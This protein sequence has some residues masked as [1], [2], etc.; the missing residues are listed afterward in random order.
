MDLKLLLF[1]PC[2]LIFAEANA[3][4]Q[5]TQRT[6][7][8]NIGR[9]R[10]V[11][12]SI[13]NRAYLGLGHYN[14]TGVE[15]YFSDWW[16]FDPATGAWTQ[17][18]DYPGNSG[19]GE[20][21]AHGMGL[22]S[23][24]FVGLGELDDYSLYK[25]DPQTNSWTQVASPTSI[26]GTF[27]DTGDF[28]I[29]HKGYFMRISSDQLWEYDADLDSWT[30][31][32]QPPFDVYFSFSGFSINGKGYLKTSNNS[33]TVNDFWEYDPSL[34]FWT[35]KA[36][37]P[38]L[39][40]L[41]SISFVQRNKGYIICGYGVNAHSDLTSEVWQYSPSTNSWAQLE[42]FAGTKRRYS[43]GFN[44]G[45]RC[46]LG[47]GTNGTNLN[48]FW[49]FDAVA[50]LEDNLSKLLFTTYPNPANHSINFHSDQWSTYEIVY[51]NSQGSIQGQVKS[52][53]GAARIN[54]TDLQGM[55][56]YHI[57]VDGQIVHKGKFVFQGD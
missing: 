20:L 16:E 6:D 31:K 46:Y 21:G 29:G 52:E 17:K 15:T 28:T 30:Q 26:G 35:L 33:L 7:F 55:Y 53:F 1:L 45:E 43:V 49:E 2:L 27:Q 57:L 56:F 37:F 50:G 3:S 12:I 8:G 23:V 38:G 34:D 14:G 40:R 5:W 41:S 24:G 48:D 11:G 39:A 32:N 47:T 22:E 25:Y 36:V 4:H 54:R 42:N 13:G 19:N 18:V 44:I 10:A 51:F 9:H